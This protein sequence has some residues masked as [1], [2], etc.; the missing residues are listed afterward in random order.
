L[1]ENL[2]ILYHNSIKWQHKKGKKSLIFSYFFRILGILKVSF[3]MPC[4]MQLKDCQQLLKNTYTTSG[5]TDN[6]SQ[7][8]QSARGDKKS[9]C[10][11][12]FGGFSQIKQAISEFKK[13]EKALSQLEHSSAPTSNCESKL[14]TTFRKDFSQKNNLSK[15]ATDARSQQ[16]NSCLQELG[17]YAGV[18]TFLKNIEN[19]YQELPSSL[20]NQAQT[21]TTTSSPIIQNSQEE[22]TPKDQNQNYQSLS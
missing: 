9:E 2:Y 19:N 18:S 3:I 7:L 20:P 11:N 8:T 16:K 10:I 13:E 6:L 1:Q 21:S 14:I 22:T 17:G 12:T 15:L 4:T 5:K